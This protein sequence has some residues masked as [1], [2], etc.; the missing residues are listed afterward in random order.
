MVTYARYEGLGQRTTDGRLGGSD[1]GRRWE[2]RLGNAILGVAGQ[3][4]IAEAGEEAK[5]ECGQSE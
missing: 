3:L 2:D 1:G 4:Y 5:V